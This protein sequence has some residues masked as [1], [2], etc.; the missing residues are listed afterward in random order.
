MLWMNRQWKLFIA[1]KLVHIRKPGKPGIVQTKRVLTAHNSAVKI[2]GRLTLLVQIGPRLPEVEQEFVITADK[3]IEC[4][5]ELI[6]WKP[7]K[8]Y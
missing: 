3:G 7:I 2:I 5:L 6:S 1:F 8:V 4:P